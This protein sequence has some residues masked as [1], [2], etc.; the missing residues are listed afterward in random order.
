MKLLSSLIAIK[1]NEAGSSDATADDKAVQEA[2]RRILA[3]EKSFTVDDGKPGT[4]RKIEITAEDIDRTIEAVG[5]TVEKL[6]PD[7]A[8][9]SAKMILKTAKKSAREGLE[10]RR[11]EQDYFV[12]KLRQ[13]WGRAFDGLALEVELAAEAGNE[14]A[15]WQYS[16]RRIKNPY[17]L[18][19]LHRL[20][21]RACLTAG[22]VQA[23]LEAGFADGALARWRTLHEVAVVVSFLRENGE[24]SAERYLLHDGIDSLRIAEQYN[25][26][27]A[28]TGT[29]AVP[30]KEMEALQ[31][32]ATR[33]CRRF[34]KAFG[35]EYGWAA[36]ALKKESPRFADI[37]RAVGLSHARQHYKMASGV[38]HAGAKGTMFKLGLI[39]GYESALL[40]GPSNA[41]LDE[42]GRLTAYSLCQVTSDLLLSHPTLDTIVWSKIMFA[43]QEE[44]A[45]LFERCQQ[46]LE[47][48]ERR[49]GAKPRRKR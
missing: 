4:S 45:A 18:E 9:R 42:A 13:R 7:M 3:G 34:G 27:A 49:G 5:A 24:R 38:I 14:M 43:V 47:R 10:A 35:N 33:L 8:E 40:A 30:K 48:E 44:T 23:L 19:A 36:E 25:R 37:E 31:R 26:Q 32:N 20:H 12:A 6:V 16:R 28:A 39:A 2:A 46:Q 21:A 41:G 22:E 11:V 17:L 29:K 1:L 15:Q